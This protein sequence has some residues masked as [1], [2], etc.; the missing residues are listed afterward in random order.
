MKLEI[1]AGAKWEKKVL[2]RTHDA[3]FCLIV[4]VCAK[5]LV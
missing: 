2:G 4:E 1:V 3:W 5:E